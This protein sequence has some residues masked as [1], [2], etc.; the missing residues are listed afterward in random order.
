MR[1]SKKPVNDISMLLPQ[2]AL[3]LLPPPLTV[4]LKGALP[5]NLPNEN[6]ATQRIT[7]ATRVTLLWDAT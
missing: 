6:Y 4:Q 1:D 7:I 2:N 3:L 5:I